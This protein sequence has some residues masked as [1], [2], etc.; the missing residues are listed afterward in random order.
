V[1]ILDDSTSHAA[2]DFLKDKGLSSYRK[3]Y[4]TKPKNHF[5]ESDSAE[6]EIV[7]ADEIVYIGKKQEFLKN[8]LKSEKK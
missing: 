7:P 1:N 8:N 2:C 6:L 5:P 4:M 3:I